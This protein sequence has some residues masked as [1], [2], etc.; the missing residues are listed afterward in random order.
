MP[1]I[2]SR[3]LPTLRGVALSAAAK[4]YPVRTEFDHLSHTLHHGIKVR[5]H[6]R[7]ELICPN[8]KKAEKSA[9]SGEGTVKGIVSAGPIC[10]VRVGSI[11]NKG[12]EDLHS[13][14][15]LRCETWERLKAQ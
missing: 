10:N 1:E 5:I 3:L 12:D 2:D 6:S 11:H 14:S 8:K 13:S 15:T 7:R 9:P 4:R